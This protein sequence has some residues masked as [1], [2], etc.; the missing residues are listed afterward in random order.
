MDR[1]ARVQF[2][3]DDG[4]PAG[5]RKLE[6]LE[7]RDLGRSRFD[8]VPD[9]RSTFGKMCRIIEIDMVDR[10]FQARKSP[11]EEELWL[12]QGRIHDKEMDLWKLEHGDD[13]AP[14]NTRFAWESCGCSDWRGSPGGSSSCGSWCRVISAGPSIP[15]SRPP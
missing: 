9:A 2:R 4:G 3:E 5:Y 12:T 14:V 15:P 11:L 6:V 1:E 10:A 8:R 13:T 7:T